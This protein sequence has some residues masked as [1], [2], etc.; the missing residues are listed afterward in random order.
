MIVISDTTPINYLVMIDQ[1]DL[2]QVVPR[3][4]HTNFRAPAALIAHLLDVDAKRRR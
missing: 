1:I 3:L 2:S 4:M